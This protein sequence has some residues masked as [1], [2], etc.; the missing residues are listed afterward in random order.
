MRVQ[1]RGL[2]AYVA[3]LVGTL[4][5]TFAICTVVVLY[6]ATSANAQSGSDFAVVGLVHGIVLFALII[7]L[8]AAS[9]GHFNP[10]V[11]LAAAILR[12]IDPV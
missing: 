9:G 10:V 8:G 4:L 2:A 6:V 7:T 1:D 5:L 12:R 11:T 3:E